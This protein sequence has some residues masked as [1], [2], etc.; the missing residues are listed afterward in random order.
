MA[1][2][3]TDGVGEGKLGMVTVFSHSDQAKME[4]SVMLLTL[5]QWD[6]HELAVVLM[7]IFTN[8]PYFPWGP[9]GLSFLDIATLSEGTPTIQFPLSW[10]CLCLPK[11]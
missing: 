1:I 10:L 8:S 9:F 3:I 7:K 2:L 5:V 11:E 4:P 6:L